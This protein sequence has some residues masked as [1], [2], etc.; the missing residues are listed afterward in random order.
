MNP[1]T[2]KPKAKRVN[3]AH[4]GVVE[5]IKEYLGLGKHSK[6]AKKIDNILAQDPTS[7]QPKRKKK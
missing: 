7:P 6:P 2:S 5:K 1:Y 3:M 4:G